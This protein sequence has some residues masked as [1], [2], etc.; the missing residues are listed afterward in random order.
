MLKLFPAS[1]RLTVANREDRN[2]AEPISERQSFVSLHKMPVPLPTC[3]PAHMVATAPPLTP[4]RALESLWNM[5]H[6]HVIITRHG[7]ALLDPDKV[8]L[9]KLLLPHLV[10]SNICSFLAS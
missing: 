4:D 2:R 7:A 6:D 8:A 3:P 10:C 9:F 5:L 1:L